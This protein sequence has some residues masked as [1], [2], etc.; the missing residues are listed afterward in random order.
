MWSAPRTEN[1]R[2]GSAGTGLPLNYKDLRRS[3]GDWPVALAC[4][5]FIRGLR[6]RDMPRL[7]QILL[8]LLACLW[9]AVAP[10]T[11]ARVICTTPCGHQAVEPLHQPGSCPANSHEGHSQEDGEEEPCSDRVLSGEMLSPDGKQ[12]APS[13]EFAKAITALVPLW[14]EL[15]A[16]TAPAIRS[17]TYTHSPP[18]HA[19]EH[20][21]LSTIVL[22][23]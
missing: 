19:A 23:I 13:A 20:L 17:N 1:R 14:H 8:P 9:A 7:S 18:P 6:Y 2:M 21:R 15:A 22:L 4:K 11:A 16:L 12:S 5:R 10:L 3:G